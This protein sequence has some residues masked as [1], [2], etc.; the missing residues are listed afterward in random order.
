MA[1]SFA[2]SAFATT[3]VHS[4]PKKEKLEKENFVESPSF[5]VSESYE[6][7]SYGHDFIAPELLV[8]D[9]INT[10]YVIVKNSK[11]VR[12]Y[13]LV[14]NPNHSKRIRLFDRI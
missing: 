13:D 7:N 10:K 4:V 5:V 12:L 14:T 8:I 1:C 3:E 6:F 2:L 11:E 9:S